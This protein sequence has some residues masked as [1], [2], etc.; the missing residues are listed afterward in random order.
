M[1]FQRRNRKRHQA[2]TSK[3][4][5]NEDWKTVKPQKS[6]K[7]KNETQEAGKN[8]TPT[9]EKTTDELLAS[10]KT[11]LEEPTA[12][13]PLNYTQYKNFLTELPDL[14]ILPLSRMIT[15]MTSSL[16]FGSKSHAMES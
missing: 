4:K 7:S 16:S 8:I 5:S 10:I 11:I 2:T 6:K 13:Y 9:T 3:K 14:L 15:L 1:D 12:N